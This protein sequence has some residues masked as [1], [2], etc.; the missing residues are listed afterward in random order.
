MVDAQ[1]IQGVLNCKW[2]HHE[3]P[4]ELQKILNKDEN[5]P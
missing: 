1:L 5:N 3:I 4:S 2:I